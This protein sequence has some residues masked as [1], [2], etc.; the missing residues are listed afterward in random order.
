MKEGKIEQHERMEMA[1][2]NDALLAV[3]ADMQILCVR[4]L[5]DFGLVF[6]A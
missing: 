3:N 4:M 1:R 5:A 2:Q 6:V